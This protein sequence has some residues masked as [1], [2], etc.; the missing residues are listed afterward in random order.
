MQKL[1]PS[2]PALRMFQSVCV[3]SVV[4]PDADK[5]QVIETT[6]S[7]PKNAA[8]SHSDLAVVQTNVEVHARVESGVQLQAETAK[9]KSC[10]DAQFDSLLQAHFDS[11]LQAASSATH[12]RSPDR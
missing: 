11:L 5:K 7:M 8:S 3:V 12:D 4:E 1:H 10:P 2:L 9:S 6:A